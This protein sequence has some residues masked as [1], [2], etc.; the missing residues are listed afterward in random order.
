MLLYDLKKTRILFHREVTHRDLKLENILLEKENDLESVKIA[1]FGLA[2]RT[3]KPLQTMCGT[4]YYVAPEVIS[5]D[6]TKEYGK[7]VDM[8]SAGVLLYVLLSGMQPFAGNDSFDKILQ[9]EYEFD[10]PE[11]KE[12]SEE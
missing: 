2:K 11:W 1:D 3:S 5:D 10:K 8:W 7:A 6:D 4:L 12:A 9:G